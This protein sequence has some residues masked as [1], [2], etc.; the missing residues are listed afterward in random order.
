MKHHLLKF[1]VFIGLTGWL[2]ADQAKLSS[3]KSLHALR[4]VESTIIIDG[5]LD[6]STWSASNFK[7]DFIQ[8]DP[9]DGNPASERTEFAV[10]Y[11]DEF[12]Y[13]AVK[14]YTTDP[15]TI[16]GIMSRRDEETHSDWLYVS[17]DSYNDN[18]TAFEFGL[19]PVGVK[20]DLR[21][22]DDE[23][24]DS[25]W[26]ALWEGQTARMKDGWTA[27][28]KIP[29]RELRF[30]NNEHQTW[31]LQINRFIAEKNEDIYWSHIKKNEQGWV[32]HYGELN[33]IKN[34]P[35]QR[36]IYV[37]PY[38][39]GQYDK[40]NYYRNPVHPKSYNTSSNIG[41][42]MKVGVTSNLTLDLSVN[43]D[44]GQVEADPAELNLSAFESYF[45]EKRPFF[46]E[47]GN[48]YNFS[49]G[50]GDGDNSNN[51]LFYSRRIG[52]SPHNY[53]YDE[54]DE[55]EFDGYETNPSSSTILTS[56]KLSGKTSNGI[57]IGV[58]NAITAEETGIIDFDNDSTYSETIE[59]LTNYFVSRLQKDFNDGN[60]TVG[61]IFTAVNRDINEPNLEWLHNDAYSGGLDVSHRF[62]DGQYYV[63][64]AFAATDVI[65]TPE[66]ITATQRSSSHY[67]QRPDASHLEVDSSR[68]NLQGFSHKL[69]FGKLGGDHWRYLI[70]EQTVSPGFEPNDIGYNRET[71]DKS[72]FIWAQYRQDTPSDHLQRYNINFN[73][74]RGSSF[75]DE[76]PNYGGNMNA[77]MTLSN[78]W[79]I[80]GG[81]NMGGP[82]WHRYALWGGPSLRM[83]PNFN[84]WGFVSSDPRKDLTFQAQGYRGGQVTGSKFM[85]LNPSVT[86]RPTNNFSMRL[87]ASYNLLDDNWSTWGSYE[88]T[89]DEQ[90]LD[91]RSDY[92]MSDLYQE[93]LRATLRLDFT[94][95]PNLS[96]QFYGSPFV[97]AGHFY[98]F[99]RVINPKADEWDNR[100]QEFVNG[101]T[102]YDAENEVYYIDSDM[103]GATNYTV[104]NNDFNYKAFN[105]NLVVRWEYRPGSTFYLVWSNGL[106]EYI[107]YEG[108]M[109]F[110][111]DVRNMMK[112]DAENILLLK[113]SYLLNI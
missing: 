40:A 46:I 66:A 37:S 106:S 6:E 28:F 78:Y 86:W 56:A 109:N 15:S 108:E 42:D 41:A 21:R 89:L 105:S 96:I 3:P 18:R 70:G 63:E 58:M 57:S 10:A 44:F 83:D 81:F 72:Y 47:G 111:S 5:N 94:L 8:R 62:L 113:F 25:N 2:S 99:K 22:Y 23:N 27:E 35:K 59:P 82:G 87:Y 93:T 33:G 36:R 49:L 79:S 74:W 60:T 110:G 68:T 14:A 112:L 50:I 73:L 51:S 103:D 84:T 1:T 102:T 7:S 98:N 19:N 65:G 16:K 26:D 12:L 11:D 29:F 45:S 9:V 92:L 107:S 48:I 53:I 13:V 104:D 55:D 64:A 101:E 91:E 38:I 31:G 20:H 67:Y 97:T 100:Y 76:T 80:G 34:I 77:R 32:S 4:V 43:P 24:H 61:G 71:D 39:T 30:D 17:V 90:S 85:G 95:T 52:R 54:N 75:G 69:A 88:P